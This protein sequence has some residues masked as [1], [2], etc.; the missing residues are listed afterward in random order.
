MLIGII[1][2]MDVEVQQLKDMMVNAQTETISTVVFHRG[3]I[4]GI[5]TVV[6]VA[7]VGKVNAA[8]CA[9]T[10]ILKYHPDYIIN[11]GVAGGLLS[12]FRVGDIAVA[13]EVVQHDMDTSPLGDDP[14]FITGINMVYI[15]CDKKLS[16]LIYTSAG[17]VNGIN[18]FK[19]IIASGDQFIASQEQRNKIITGFNAI[20]AEMEGASIGHVCKMNNVPFGVIR[21]ISDGANSDSAMDFPTF[22]KMAVKNSIEIITQMLDRIKAGALN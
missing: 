2:A 4:N 3:L 13:T 17:H 6:A 16:E 9:Q 10:M 14:G 20:A 21:A 7:G 1:G 5:C 12:E 11:A 15:P 18:V 22:T 8:V 19:G